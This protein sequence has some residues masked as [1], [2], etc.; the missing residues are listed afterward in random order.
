M[1]EKL[2]KGWVKTTLGEVSLP[3]ATVQ[4][5]TTLDAEFTYFDIGGINNESNRIVET[6]TVTG[7]EAPSRARRVV[8]TNDI[9]F[10]T[11]R[12][13][14]KKIARIE[15]EYPNP[16][17][18]TGFA[19]I[20][21]APGVSSE[22]L[23][24]QILS[25]DFLQ[26]LNALQT[27]TSYPAVRERDVFAQPIL[28]PPTREQDRIVAKLHASLSRVA[29]GEGVA[30]RASD[31]LER[32][33][34]AVLH[35][36]VTGEL[37]RDW[38]KTHK[39]HE[40]GA[41][42]LQ[43]LLKTRHSRWEESELQRRRDTGKPPKDDKW[44]SRYE[45]PASPKTNRLPEIPREWVWASPEQLSSGNRHALA[46]G[47][48]GSN[49]KVSDYTD[50]G[51][52]LIFVRNIRSGDFS[53]VNSRFISRKKAVEL[54]AHKVGGGDILITKMGDPPGDASLY[55]ENALQ[56]I[57]TAD[58]IRLELSPVL[59]KAK[60]FFVYCINSKLG[61]DQIISITKGVA[62][63]KVSL[64]RFVAIALPLPALAE[65]IEIVRETRRRL[66]AVDRLATTL[67][68][69]LDC[70][71]ATRQSLLRE[72]L[73]G[74][75]V[76]QEPTDEPASVLL[77]R[78]RVAREAEAKQPKGKRMP[79]P[80]SR[81]TRRPLLDV[82]GEHKTSITPEQ[83]FRE[84]GFQPAQADVFYRELASLRK[85][86]RETKPPASAAKAWPHRAHV[87]L[88]LKER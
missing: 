42:L 26:P 46:I 28:L 23:F 4:P 64:S 5:K 40:T 17:A 87:L 45:E 31:R 57:I 85:I 58:C 39:P 30:R 13:Y 12:T 54:E 84:A 71:R 32:Y 53:R 82:L 16:V 37:S 49:L 61:R 35:A 50:S 68:H 41:Q 81:I 80:R 78:I 63:Q 62:Q 14:L 88:K 8:Q 77:E 67:N 60:R 76:P 74:H 55:P 65:Q 2:P 79:K 18:S 7:R 1:P 38:R 75:L 25:E 10:S 52:P 9:L 51:V 47:P 11:V 22:F 69:Q 36:A 70:A 3:V 83:L 59:E 72:A 43:R 34:A 33:R 15:R 21:A 20:R 27:G 86:L 29:A 73:A 6:K 19:V 56:A 44:R 48:F 24:F 66:E